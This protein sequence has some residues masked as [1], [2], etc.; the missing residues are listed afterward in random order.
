M[1]L[2]GVDSSHYTGSFLYVPLVNESYWEFA[3]DDIQIG[4]QSLGFCDSGCH[5]IADTGTSLL[6]G[7][8]DMVQTINNKLGAIG[9]LSEECQMLVDQY[10]DQIINGIIDGLNASQICT[11]IG[12]CPGTA[13]CGVC[14]MV[15]G[16]L[17]TVLPSNSSETFIKIVLDAVCD[18]LPSPNGE[19]IVDCSTIPTLPNIEIVL[20]SKSFT[21]TPQ[22]YIL[23]EGIGSES[24]CLSGFIGLDLPPNIGPLWILGDVFIGA[25]YTVFDYGNKQVG[26]ATAV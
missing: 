18:L 17:V 19:S 9:V 3:I 13:E 26:F 10:E 8:S 23:Q 7:P 21:L 24:L 6:A 11:N 15:I 20:N 25:Y 5:G 2:G 16:F 14:K 12:V 22:Q 1:I 4:G